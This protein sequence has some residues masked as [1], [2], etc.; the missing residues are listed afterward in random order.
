MPAKPS[1]TLVLLT[2]LL[3]WAFGSQLI[4]ALSWGHDSWQLT[5]C[6]INYAGGFVRRGLM[7]SI[8]WHLSH[9]TGIQGNLLAIGITFT[10]F[11][12]LT[13]W[14]L[15]VS[16]RAFPP[17]LILSCVVMG[18][19]AY[20]D[21]ILRKDCIALL[22]LLGCLKA[23]TSR[24][25][26]PLALF[27]VNLLACA[28]IL[29]HECFAFYALPAMALFA[30][31][32][33]SNRSFIGIVRKSLA[34]LPSAACLLL[35]IQF[36]GSPVV[37]DAVNDSWLPLWRITDP[38]SPQIG[39][40]VAAIGAIGWTS[41]EGLSVGI[42]LLTSGFYQP[43]AWLFVYGVSFVLIVLFTGRDGLQDAHG[44]RQAK[45]EIAAILAAQ[46]VFMAPMFLLGHDYGRWVFY[47]S[48]SSLMLHTL[49]LQP[50]SWMT[51]PFLRLF[52]TLNQVHMLA[53]LP[54]KEW[55]LLFFGVPVC[56]NIQTFLISSPVARLV[57]D[58]FKS[59]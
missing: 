28:A 49:G 16:T 57:N 11:L 26:R 58:L 46:F 33:E 1:P 53:R 44:A 59:F 34:L 12:L 27:L 39:T 47:W 29:N 13:A 32:H 37:A 51:A 31:A 55:Y 43:S 45:A 42:N 40:A 38:G 19:P 7:G 6:L 56:W 30:N 23:D 17:I 2:G 52:N 50:P 4:A 22:F 9:W 48:G 5:E 41:A 54:V 36:H 15:R 35:S 24:L 14:F 3:L 21:S 18:F 8:I 25:P 20:Q 10:C